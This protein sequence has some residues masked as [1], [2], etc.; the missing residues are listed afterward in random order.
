M[1]VL[2]QV[3]VRS[4]TFHRARLLRL[5]EAVLAEV[6]ESSAELGVSFIGDR[7]MRKLNRR[8][9]R[10][11]RSTDVLAF[12]MREARAPHVSRLRGGQLGDVVISVPTAL[13]Q[14]RSGRR[15]VDEEVAALLVHGMLHLCGYDHER[16]EAEARRMH[17]RERMVLHRL[18][19]IP[20]LVRPI[21]QR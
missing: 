3:R 14:A 10:K 21:R 16:S 13:R 17:R 20:S 8:F 6:G 9:R 15:S 18:G 5:V 1:P 4:V 2:F 7:R 19:K 12:A 11:D